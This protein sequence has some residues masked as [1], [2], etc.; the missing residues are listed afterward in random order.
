MSQ[1]IV[2]KRISKIQGDV[3]V[4][5]KLTAFEITC[6]WVRTTMLRVS[7]V[8]HSTPCTL[9]S[10]GIAHISQVLFYGYLPIALTFFPENKCKLPILVS[11]IM[12]RFSYLFT[13]Q[14]KIIFGG[15]CHILC[16]NWHQLDR[17]ATQR[18]PGFVWRS[19]WELAW[20]ESCICFSPGKLHHSSS[21]F[22]MSYQS[23][24]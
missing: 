4:Y 10:S 13:S 6:M 1:S 9:I 23:S 15:N 19:S 3:C 8:Q 12:N 24:S 16:C 18:R 11:S 21:R 2:H 17:V 14:I 5:M 7:T 22:T 20:S